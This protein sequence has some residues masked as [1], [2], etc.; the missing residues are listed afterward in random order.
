MKNIEIYSRPVTSRDFPEDRE[1]SEILESKSI[2][3]KWRICP[4]LPDL[5]IKRM[6]SMDKEKL[7]EFVE[8]RES[9][10]HN[11]IVDPLKHGFDISEEFGYAIDSKYFPAQKIFDELF[12]DGKTPVINSLG[13]NRAGKTWFALKRI[14]KYAIENNDKKIC[15]CSQLQDTSHR[16]QQEYVFQFLPPEYKACGGSYGSRKKDS[17]AVAEFT[18]RPGGSGGFVNNKISFSNGSEIHFQMYS[19]DPGVIE[20]TS[21]DI[22]FMDEEAPGS[23]Y[24]TVIFRL[25]KKGSQLI[26][27]F[28]PVTGETNVLYQIMEDA[29][30][31]EEDYSEILKEK[32]PREMVS[33]DGDP[34]LFFWSED[35]AFLDIDWYRDKINRCGTLYKKMIRACGY[36]K[37][38]TG[39]V[40]PNFSL[41]KNIS[42]KHQ[43][44]DIHISVYIPIRRDACWYYIVANIDDGIVYIVSETPVDVWCERNDQGE[45]A[46]GDGQL[47]LKDNSA[48]MWISKIKN[49]KPYG[50]Y[51]NFQFDEKDFEYSLIGEFDKYN[52]PIDVCGKADIHYRVG[53]IN[54]FINDG[55]LK[56]YKECKNL[57]F[58]IKNFKDY[59]DEIN[60]AMIIALSSMLMMYGGQVDISDDEIIW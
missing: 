29:K 43:S 46:P 6:A 42:T 35:N 1:K 28:T 44:G 31:V 12:M 39:K 30:M 11:A 55:R 49:E 7:K 4:V 21:W 14:T 2:P 17:N 27:N 36:I 47:A 57:I 34:I 3:L 10:I 20:G 5:D 25:D 19:Q 38:A 8:N 23:L 52:C 26:M 16:V 56:I 32:C 15:V 24:S 33:K 18:K 50:V 9:K 53:V 60:G 58:S 51:V 45:F 40:F 37:D 48:K 13:G 22:L 41:E 59:N 54:D